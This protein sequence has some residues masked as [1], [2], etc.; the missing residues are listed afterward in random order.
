M[1]AQLKEPESTEI[2]LLPE[3]ALANPVDLFTRAALDDV[4]AQIRAATVTLVPDLTTEQGR[5]Q[6]ASTAYT[7]SRSKT[8]LDEAGKSLVEDRKAQVKAIDV[9]RKH[10]KDTL[11]ALRDEVRAPLTEWEAEQARIEQEAIEAARLRREAE[12]AERIAELERREAAIREAEERIAAAEKAEADRIAAEQAERER[13]EREDAIRAEAAAQAERDAAAAVEKAKQDAID[14][15]ARRQREAEEARQA[16]EAAAQRAAEEKA[17]AVRQ[18]EAR[19]AQQAADA[20][21]A[22]KDAEAAQRAEDERRA[23]NRRHCGAINRKAAAALV[24]GGLSEADAQTVITL[25]AT[26]KVPAVSITY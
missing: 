13:V 15:E 6:I 11:D 24:A 26:G 23:A 22:R 9:L 18:A 20:E 19:A 12:E 1:N 21:R 4:L 8:A 2:T 14:A 3:N 10:A 25:V 16:A 5:K 7:V 17:E